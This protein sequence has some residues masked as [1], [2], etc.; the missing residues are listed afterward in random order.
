MSNVVSFNGVDGQ[1]IVVGA[2]SLLLT[3]EFTIIM[4]FKVIQKY[5]FQTYLLNRNNYYGLL[6]G[7]TTTY[8]GY[9]NTVEFFLAGYAGDDLRVLS[10][11]NIPDTGWHHVAYAYSNTGTS[12]KGFLDAQRIF[13]LVKTTTLSAA[14]GN[15]AI[16][17]GGTGNYNN[18]MISE[19][20]IYNRQLS[21]DEIKQ[22]YEH[23]GNPIRRGLV[24]NLTQESIY[25]TQWNDLSGN[26][27]NG[28]YVNGALPTRANLVTQR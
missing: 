12:W 9:R 27:N 16:G 6:Y 19:M 2:A 10:G 1:V 21:D 11:I 25:G 17:S 8:T 18:C 15:M 26:A 23:P 22:N 24:L 4:R 5:Q 28:T 3:T 7:Y 20:Q 13:S 14:A